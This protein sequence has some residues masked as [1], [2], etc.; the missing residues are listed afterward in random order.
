MFFKA[1]ADM[2]NPARTSLISHVVRFKAREYTI[3]HTA[4]HICQWYVIRDPSWEASFDN[5]NAETVERYNTEDGPWQ[6]IKSR[7][8]SIVLINSGILENFSAAPSLSP[9][10]HNR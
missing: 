9:T 2:E 4:I 3:A 8:I 6:Q 1:C 10:I 7:K 5:D